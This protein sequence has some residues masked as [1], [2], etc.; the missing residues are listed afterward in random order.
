MKFFIIYDKTTGVIDRTF[1]GTLAEA[2]LNVL[3]SEDYLLRDISLKNGK[4]YVS[5]GVYAV[6]TK[7]DLTYDS[8]NGQYN[9]PFWLHGIPAGTII[10]GSWFKDRISL[11]ESEVFTLKLGT[12]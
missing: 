6:C 11:G 3:Q 10:S 12:H 1:S 7:F 9:T 8:T 2:K 4:Y 5:G